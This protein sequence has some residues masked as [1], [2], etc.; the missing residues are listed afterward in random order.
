MLR[1][2]RTRP[3]VSALVGLARAAR[4]P[5]SAVV[6]VFALV[7][8]LAVVAFGTMIGDAVHRGQ[9]AAVLARG[10][11]RRG[12]RGLGLAR[13]RSPRAAARDIAAVPGAVRTATVAVIARAAAPRPA[14]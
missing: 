4:T 10:R 8:A 11:R 6:P 7:L 5:A 14:G 12:D 9:V 3:G 2:A 13:G 1:L